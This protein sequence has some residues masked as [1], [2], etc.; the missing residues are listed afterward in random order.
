MK[1]ASARRLVG[2]A[3]LLELSL[4]VIA[5]ALGAIFGIDPLATLSWPPHGLVAGAFAAVPLLLLFAVAWR[6]RVPGLRRIRTILESIL[7]RLF[8]G[9]STGGLATVCL[10]AGLGEEIFFRGFLQAALERGL[11]TSAGLTAASLLFGLAHPLSPGY[12]VV[13][14]AMGA[15]LGWLWQ[16][17][18]NLWIPVATHAAYDFVVLRVLLSRG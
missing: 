6:S 14:G 1:A 13:A 4:A 11:G 10:A 5:C 12:I 2:Q 7:P 17:T 15:Y 3:T 9:V 16:L 18:D 8:A